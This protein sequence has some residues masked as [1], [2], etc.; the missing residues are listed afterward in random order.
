MVVSRGNIIAVVVIM[1]VTTLA[2]LILI[3]YQCYASFQSRAYDRRLGRHLATATATG[4]PTEAPAYL[5]LNRLRSMTEETEVD[6]EWEE[7]IFVGTSGE[8]MG[9]VGGVET[10]AR[11]VTGSPEAR[12]A[13][14]EEGV[15]GVGVL[16]GEAEVADVEEVVGVEEEEGGAGGASTSMK[17][18]DRGESLACEIKGKGGV[19]EYE[20]HSLE[21]QEGVRAEETEVEG[22][23][24]HRTFVRFL[25]IVQKI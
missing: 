8:E 5:S 11:M 10:G 6:G 9:A 22:S 12:M 17:E 3:G 13:R 25:S 16:E 14:S 4:N 20:L 1:S 19:E 7:D 21:S 24:D 2:C 18:N 23:R 15:R